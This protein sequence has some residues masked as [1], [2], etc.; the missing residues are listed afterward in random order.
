[1][2]RPERRQ[3]RRART[4]YGAH[5]NRVCGGLEK[6]PGGA[7]LFQYDESWLDWSPAFPISLTLRG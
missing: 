5:H 6:E 1:M 2:D 3:A 4:A 7:T